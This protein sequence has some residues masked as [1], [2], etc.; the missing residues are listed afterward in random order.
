MS[1]W[2]WWLSFADDTKPQGSQWLGCTVVCA[3]DFMAAILRA[4]MLRINPGG[5]VAGWPVAPVGVPPPPAALR[6]KLVRDKTQLGALDEQ[7]MAALD[8]FARLLG[9]SQ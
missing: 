7:W 8:E 4:H 1:R 5:Q 3:P 9:M 2:W 6:N